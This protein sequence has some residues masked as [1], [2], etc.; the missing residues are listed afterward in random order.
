MESCRGDPRLARLQSGELV[1]GAAAA[2]AS[3]ERVARVVRVVRALVRVL[4][5]VRAPVR[6]A[7]R[8]FV[9]PAFAFAAVEAP[10]GAGVSAGAFRTCDD[11]ASRPWL[12]AHSKYWWTHPQRSPA[13][14]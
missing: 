10:G 2:S 12:A 5:L 11:L 13:G 14:S 4:A 7:M 9:A 8:D 6:V 3:E 1:A